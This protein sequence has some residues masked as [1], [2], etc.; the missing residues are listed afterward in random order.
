MPRIC[1]L[2]IRGKAKT[3]LFPSVM[4][5]NE[6][7]STMFA[8]SQ[9]YAWGLI[10]VL[11][12]WSGSL[13]LLPLPSGKTEAFVGIHYLTLL[14]SST[15]VL[16]FGLLFQSPGSDEQS[17]PSNRRRGDSG[18]GQQ[19][20]SSPV[21]LLFYTDRLSYVLLPLTQSRSLVNDSI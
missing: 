19:W 8:T 21:D 15:G 12:L 6:E 4:N 3:S 20:L 2:R 7:D 14:T 9:L 1:S 16:L 10:Y 18:I 5:G 17:I 11:V 13:L